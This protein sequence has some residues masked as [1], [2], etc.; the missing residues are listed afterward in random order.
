ML[1]SSLKVRSPSRSSWVFSTFFY[2]LHYKRFLPPVS[3][4]FFFSPFFPQPQGNPSSALSFFRCQSSVTYRF[5]V[6]PTAHH[7]TPHTLPIYSAMILHAV[8]FTPPLF[9]HAVPSVSLYTPS[10]AI[11]CV[12]QHILRTVLY[13]FVSHLC[14]PSV[15]SL[16]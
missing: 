15:S 13:A 8:P 5:A 9:P 6:A 10:A 14:A 3:P 11:Q 12:S 2:A 7:C 4:A 16:L 1:N